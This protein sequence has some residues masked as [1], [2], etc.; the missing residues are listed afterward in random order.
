MVVNKSHKL[1]SV[2]VV[3]DKI[4]LKFPAFGRIANDE[5]IP[6]VKAQFPV[7]IKGIIQQE[8]PYHQ[9]HKKER[10]KI[11]QLFTGKI[12]ECNRL[13]KQQKQK[14]KE[15]D[16]FYISKKQILSARITINFIGS[17]NK[18][19]DQPNEIDVGIKQQVC[20]ARAILLLT[21]VTK[22]DDKKDVKDQEIPNDGQ[23]WNI[24]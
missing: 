4:L 21:G 8:F 7:Q 12:I 19:Q 23:G 18:C 2:P 17:E 13:K 22:P 9:Q 1:V 5:H 15:N 16:D 10:E 20:I 24:F 6:E 11:L 3:A 14:E